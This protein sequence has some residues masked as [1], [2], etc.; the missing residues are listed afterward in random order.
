LL[1]QEFSLEAILSKTNNWRTQKYEGTKVPE[2]PEAPKEK[3][4]GC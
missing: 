3:E 4:A 2:A 1:A